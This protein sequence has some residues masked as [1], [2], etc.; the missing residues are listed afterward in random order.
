MLLLVLL[1]SVASAS[2]LSRNGEEPNLHGHDPLDIHNNPDFAWMLN[3]TEEAS[4]PGRIVG[5]S[6]VK[7][8]SLPYQVEIQTNGYMCGG[9]II[10][11]RYVLTAMHCLSDARQNKH[12][13]DKVR[14]VVGEHNICDGVNEGGQMIGVEKFIERADYNKPYMMN[15]IAIL[16]LKSD[17]KFSDKVKPACI[18]TD[19]SKTYVGATATV[20]GWGGTVA[21]SPEEGQKPNF[22]QKTSCNLKAT[23]CAYGTKTDSC[24]GDPGGPLVVVENGKYVLV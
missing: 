9:T 17:I 19:T 20:S 8:Y 7:A 14:V 13:V 23:N 15:D 4:A 6:V 1:A 16:K 2:V 11:K 12:P 3:S 24:Q 22:E 5:G 21:N 18:P 10:N